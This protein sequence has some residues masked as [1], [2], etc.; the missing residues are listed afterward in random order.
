MYTL[1]LSTYSHLIIVSLVSENTVI[2]KKQESD[3]KHAVYLVNMIKDILIENN[4]TVK[5][6]DSIVCVNGPGSFTGLR[7]GLSV[8]KTLAY[9]LNIPIYLISSLTSNLIS[10]KYDGN[11][12]SVIED[13]KGYYISVFDKDNNSIIEE[14]F[15]TDLSLYNDYY[16]VSEEIDIL[17]VV[18]Y[19][20][21]TSSVN[22]HLVRANYVKTIEAE[23]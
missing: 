1:F 7:I 12:I 16:V 14:T 9:S 17:E 2:I 10:S 11:K 15:V 8:G 5:S 21:R 19:A 18:K 13:G 3:S 6:L 4:L 23:K 20:K 22:P